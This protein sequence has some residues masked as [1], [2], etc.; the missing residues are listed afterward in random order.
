MLYVLLFDGH[1]PFQNGKAPGTRKGTSPYFTRPVR[2]SSRYVA[3]EAFASGGK[4][5]GFKI[6]YGCISGLLDI[7]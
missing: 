1:T 3:S 6:S 4:L 7:T 5:K 2:R